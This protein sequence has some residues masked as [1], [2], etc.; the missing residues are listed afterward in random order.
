[1][2]I[3][4]SVII[5]C[6]NSHATIGK[7]L[8]SVL[9]QSDFD[10]PIEVIVV[11]DASVDDTVEI[12]KRKLEYTPDN[13]SCIVVS[14]NINSGAS[15]TRN[16]GITHA[17]GEYILFLDSD[18]FYHESK[19]SQI[20]YALSNDVEFMFHD[21]TYSF[22][23]EVENFESYKTAFRLPRYFKY[24]NLIRNTICTPCVVIKRSAIQ[25][26]STEL[27]RMED[28]EL[29]TR[30]MVSGVRVHYLN[31]PL[32]ELGHE[33]NKGEG[34]SSDN[35]AMRGS[36]LEMFKILAREFMSLRLL[37]PFYY[38]VHNIKKTRDKVRSFTNRL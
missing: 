11:D 31:S 13:V 1:M 32:V 22:K 29:W 9:S 23:N 30:L 16:T 34:L 7:C 15:V 38:L 27:Q 3:K 2:N 8:D 17:S 21:F 36:E 26:F 4:F 24:L 18:D 10:L 33:L 19:F 6:F 20:N 25:E 14:N 37:Y 12:V 5:P 35:N 28:L